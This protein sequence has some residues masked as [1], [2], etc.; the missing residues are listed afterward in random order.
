MTLAKYELI[1][2]EKAHHKIARMCAWL[3]VSRSGYY[4]WRGRPASAAAQRRA[5][6][7]ALVAEIFAGSHE[8]YGYRRVHAALARRGEHCSA[9]LVRA[10]MR[11]QGLVPAQVRAFRPA[12]T[13]Q[14]DFRGIPDL[15]GR[16]FTA[17]RPGLKLVGDITYVRT[18]EG[19]LY[20]ATVID[21]RSKAVLGWAMADHYRT[22]LVKDA[23]R[24]AAGTGLLQPGAVFH[25]DRG[26]N[27]GFNRSSQHLDHGGVRW[28]G[29]PSWSGCLKGRGGSGRRTGRCGHRCVRRVGLSPRAPCSGT[30]G[31]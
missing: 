27:G 30:S 11:E 18:W 3:G 2:A 23:I 20:L 13:V 12:T 5:L 19:F 7:A 16:D 31:V 4:E 14:G 22:S 28:A 10:L 17:E 6:L 25:S 15:V 24:M 26:S 29:I 1:D 21:C 8:T 9:E